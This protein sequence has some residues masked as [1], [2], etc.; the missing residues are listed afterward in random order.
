VSSSVAVTPTTT[1]PTGPWDYNYI[2]VAAAINVG[3]QGHSVAN[4]GR[5][6]MASKRPKGKQA[7]WGFDAPRPSSPGPITSPPS[8]GASQS[9]VQPNRLCGCC[10]AGAGGVT[11]PGSTNHFARRLGVGP[12]VIHTRKSSVNPC[13]EANRHGPAPSV[14]DH[15]EAGA[16]SN[17]PSCP[18]SRMAALPTESPAEG[19]PALMLRVGDSQRPRAGEASPSP[20]SRPRG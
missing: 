19:W 3:R 16:G 6:G 14:S 20:P 13:A 9:S 1:T 7:K 12:R 18:T 2:G 8:A 4:E 11:A 5:F 17:H 15:R 10:M